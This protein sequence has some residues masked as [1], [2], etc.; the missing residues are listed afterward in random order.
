VQENGSLTYPSD[1]AVPVADGHA[2]YTRYHITTKPAPDVAPHPHRFRVRVGKM[3]LA[4]HLVRELFHS[5]LN[6][7]I[8]ASRPCVYGVFSGPIGGFA[9]RPKLCVG[10]LRCMTEYP[11]FVLVSPN[12]DRLLLGDS[13]FTPQHV[14]TVTYEA[15]TGN[16]PVKG[17]GYRGRFG[18]EG[19]DAMWTDMSE[20]VRPTRDGIHGREFISTAVDVGEKLSYITFDMSGMPAGRIPR[21]TT[22][23]L[24]VIF[25]L[26]PAS[27]TSEVSVRILSESARDLGTLAVIPLSACRKFG[28]RGA[29][30]VPYVSPSDTSALQDAAGQPRMIEMTSWDQGLYR[31]IQSLFPESIHCLRLEGIPGFESHLLQCFRSGIRTF[32]LTADYHGRGGGGEFVIDLVRTAHQALVREDCRD[33][34]TLLGSGGIIAAEHVPKAIICGLDAVALDTPL[35]VALQMRM[36]GECVGRETSR[37]DVPPMNVD[38]GVQRIMNLM[39]SWRDQLLEVMGAMGLREVRRLRGEIGRAMFQQDLE[40]EAFEGISG[41]RDA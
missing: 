17:A 18:G 38:W 34:V 5:R 4:G 28:V 10:C 19:W 13:Y 6:F 15:Q 35:F 29:H 31:K 39:A 37:F 36:I 12:P 14:D 41:Y 22:L 33:N 26:L 2:A 8:I 25:D 9:P 20:I 7:R 40:R 27:L 1:C 16:V 30:I 24:P 3:G 21:V 23:P 32:H 11:D